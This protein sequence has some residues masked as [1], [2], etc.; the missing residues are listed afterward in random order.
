MSLC[1]YQTQQ[2]STHLKWKAPPNK[3]TEHKKLRYVRVCGMLSRNAHFAIPTSFAGSRERNPP[4]T[5]PDSILE[6]IN[7]WVE[8]VGSL[9]CSGRIFIPAGTPVFLSRQKPTS[10]LI[11]SGNYFTW[12]QAFFISKAR[13]FGEIMLRLRLILMMM[14]MLLPVI[15]N[16]IITIYYY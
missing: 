1:P 14:M 7:T 9:L 11:C 12:F 8:F 6:S 16:I 4:P 2:H 10:D 15:I 3:D 5:L 13:V